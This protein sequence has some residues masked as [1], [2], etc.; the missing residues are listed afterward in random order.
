MRDDDV[1]AVL[2][3]ALRV[4]TI[5]DAHDE[6]EAAPAARFDAGRGVLEHD[7]ARRRHPEATSRLEERRGIRFPRQSQTQSLG[8][9]DARLKEIRQPCDAEDRHGIAA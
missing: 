3:Q 8:A 6:T 5:A 9:V 4:L 1:G 7:T 2:S